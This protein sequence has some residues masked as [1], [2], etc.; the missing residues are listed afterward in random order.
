MLRRSSSDVS[1]GFLDTGTAFHEEGVD[2][3]AGEA[4][5]RALAWVRKVSC[6]R[7]FVSRPRIDESSRRKPF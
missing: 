4:R 1:K 5:T 2:P 3:L 7:A 6:N